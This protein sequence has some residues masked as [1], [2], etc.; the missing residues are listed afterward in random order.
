MSNQEPP[1]E[2]QSKPSDE[3]DDQELEQVSG[4]I[5]DGA[6]LAEPGKVEFPNLEITIKQK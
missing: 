6:P 5:S 1:R 3:L 4:G 2:P